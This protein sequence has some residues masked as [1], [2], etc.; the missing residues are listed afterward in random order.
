MEFLLGF[1]WCFSIFVAIVGGNYLLFTGQPI[2]GFIVIGALTS[3][4]TMVMVYAS[5]DSTHQ[6]KCKK[7]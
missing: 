3:F 7:M 5:K 4:L 2:L 6:C 1:L